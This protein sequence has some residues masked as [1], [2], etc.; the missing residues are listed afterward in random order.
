MHKQC[1]KQ[2]ISQNLIKLIEKSDKA[3][4]K[5]RGLIHEQEDRFKNFP[6]RM[7]LHKQEGA[8]P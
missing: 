8:L 5:I 2:R 7:Q 4:H 3:D 1:S 6:G